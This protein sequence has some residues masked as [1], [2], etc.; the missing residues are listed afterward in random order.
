MPWV[1][2]I[3][4][5]FLAFLLTACSTLGSL[6][7]LWQKQGYRVANPKYPTSSF[8]IA[9]S[10]FNLPK[11]S[12]KQINGLYS[13]LVLQQGQL[14]YEWY[15]EGFHQES[16]FNVKSL[17]KSIL[18]VL[19]GIALE[20]GDIRSL[21]QPIAELLPE[22]YRHYDSA[23]QIRLQDLLT[24][25]AGFNYRENGNNWVYATDNWT[26]SILQLP[27][28]AEPGERFRY[29]TPQSHLL[30]HI[31]TYSSGTDILTYAQ[32]QL[33][34]PMQISL[35]GWDK[36]P[37]GV[38]FGGSELY[39]TTRDIAAF[40]QLVL[41]RGRY[42][43][44]SLTGYTAQQQVSSEWLK[45]STLI[46]FTD[47]ENNWDYG[48]YWWLGDIEIER[49]ID[50]DQQTDQTK[51]IENRIN[52][53]TTGIESLAII[54]A[55]GYGEQ[56]LI[57]VPELDTVIVTTASTPLF[58]NSRKRYQAVHQLFKQILQQISDSA[59]EAS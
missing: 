18:S 29:G 32:Q 50:Q 24:M 30:S 44:K 23:Q 34:D 55:R 7:Y 25:S 16:A 20:R 5:V 37:D 47:V 41:N 17:S 38:Y 1:K 51:T 49:V 54:A 19:T 2:K 53:G 10:D 8:P 22:Q 42:P 48:Y 28:E 14:R 11:S 12:V 3:I 6:G 43:V 15:R 36:S 58:Y 35:R 40:G 59:A 21:Q 26:D 9:E 52:R 45:Q 46:R 13:L 33:F 27:M 56:N 39:M 31:L 4:V 57:I